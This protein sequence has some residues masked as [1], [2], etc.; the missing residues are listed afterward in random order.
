MQPQAL[1]DVESSQPLR[2]HVMWGCEYVRRVAFSGLTS[3]AR[4][5]AP[6]TCSV[7]HTCGTPT[8]TIVIAMTREYGKLEQCDVTNE[9]K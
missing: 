2:L 1:A 3:G 4:W 8:Q 7:S 6:R 9:T 5:L